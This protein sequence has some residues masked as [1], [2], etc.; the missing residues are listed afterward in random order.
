[1]FGVRNY[2]FPLSRLGNSQ[3]HAPTLP[4]PFKSSNLSRFLGIEG[5]ASQLVRSGTD[6]AR[7]QENWGGYAYRPPGLDTLRCGGVFSSPYMHL[8][9]VFAFQILFSIA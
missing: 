5:G 2:V 6:D 4:E 9:H 8:L 3:A 7:V 1:M